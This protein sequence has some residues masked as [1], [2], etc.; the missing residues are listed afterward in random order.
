MLARGAWAAGVASVP[1]ARVRVRCGMRLAIHWWILIALGLGIAS[2]LAIN[3]LWTNQT[4]ELIGVNAPAAWLAHEVPTDPRVNADAGTAAWVVRFGIELT[5]FIAD[6]FVRCLRFV[7]VPIVLFSLIAA[8]AGLGNFRTLGR[9]G[10]RT[11][12]LFL[13]TAV[14]AVVLGLVLAN[15]FKPG[16][17]ISVETRQLLMAGQEQA[18]QA[19]IAN[20]QRVSGVWAML[21][22][23]VPR[24]PFDALAR[25]DM[26]QIV[27]FALVLG[28]GLT[29]LP[30]ERSGPVV[31][32]FET[33]N[34]VMI[35][36]VHALMRV[37]PVA[38][39]CLIVPVIAKL[40]TDVLQA[41]ALYCVVFAGG[42]AILLFVEYP[43]LVKVLGRYPLGRFFRGMS[44]AMLTA[45]STSSSAATL[46]VTMDCVQ[47]RL[48]VSKR[49]TSF[50][51]SVG[52]TINMDGTAL[53][54]AMATVFIAQLY[55]IELTFPQQASIV[56][57]AVLAAIGSP[58]LPSAS[59][60][61]LVVIL[62]NLNI[63][64]AGIAV[65]LGVD[66]LLDRLRTV[67]NV[68]GDAVTAV[69]VA[70]SEDEL[71]SA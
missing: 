59:I 71:E 22:E 9:I 10:G 55:G 12:A 67:V 18:A 6:L 69:I 58:G 42:L 63:P 33:L 40:G 65:V 17:S 52:A 11:V 31:A 28:M 23:L 68:A 41:L 21:L 45:F 61:F 48:G 19:S 47:G 38:V 1:A 49:V 14:V 8:A 35:G 26:L 66:A 53:Y 56:L 2:G 50:T 32:V 3:Q 60:V 30:R 70:R 25:G 24:N 37:A 64:P 44:P 7:A 46:P 36:V 16:A 27:T 39:F 15:V 13:A 43:L 57:A 20:A 51:C 4:W 54:L 34:E 29:L 62:E 5:Q